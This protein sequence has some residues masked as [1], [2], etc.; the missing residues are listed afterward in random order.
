MWA[1]KR[2]EMECGRISFIREPGGRRRKRTRTAISGGV[3][4][5]V[6]RR[7]RWVTEGSCAVGDSDQEPADTFLSL[8]LSF[9]PQAGLQCSTLPILP[10]PLFLR[11][12]AIQSIFGGRS[13]RMSFFSRKKHTQQQASTSVAPSTA[14]AAL[15]QIQQQSSSGQQQ[16]PAQKQVSKETSYERCVSIRLSSTFIPCPPALPE[17]TMD[18]PLIPSCVA[19]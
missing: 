18:R 13:R 7:I 3:A 10:L 1:G 6:V 8:P 12:A 15:A 16:Q 17:S 14:S 4:R 9:H 5:R 19:G 11:S 2:V